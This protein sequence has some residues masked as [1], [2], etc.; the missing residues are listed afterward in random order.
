MNLTNK[1]KW[2]LDTTLDFLFRTARAVTDYR[3]LYTQKAGGINKEGVEK[4]TK[5]MQIK[6][7]P[8]I[9][10]FGNVKQ[11]LAYVTGKQKRSQLR[12]KQY[13]IFDKAMTAAE[14]VGFIS[15]EEYCDRMLN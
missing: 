13:S 9:F 5:L 1:H 3:T 15:T 7:S 14:E 8:E 6:Y 4:I 2:Y 10:W 12:K 11:V